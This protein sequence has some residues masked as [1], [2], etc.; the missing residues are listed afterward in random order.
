[1][2]IKFSHR[3]LIGMDVFYQDWKRGYRVD[4]RTILN[5]QNSFRA[6]AGLE[7]GPSR[8]RFASYFQKMTLRAGAFYGQ[9]NVESN[10]NPINEYGLTFG[11]GMPIMLNRNRFDISAEFG[12]RGDKS[13]NF[14]EEMFFRLNFAISTNELWFVQQDR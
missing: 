4:D 9:L 11:L 8:D 12:R 2:A 14:V 7:R 3:F 6:G 10:G 1:M 5:M 13:L